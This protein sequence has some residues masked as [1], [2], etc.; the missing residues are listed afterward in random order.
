M[1]FIC[2]FPVKSL[3]FGIIVKLERG[4]I[5][6]KINCFPKLVSEDA[7]RYCS[8]VSQLYPASPKVH[9][10]NHEPCFNRYYNKEYVQITS[11]LPEL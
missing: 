3:T 5:V 7:D 10:Q 2:S 6:V 1:G 11:F 8:L 4:Q 9:E